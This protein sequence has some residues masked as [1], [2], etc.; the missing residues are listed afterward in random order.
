VRGDGAGAQVMGMEFGPDGALYTLDYGGGFFTVTSRSSLWKVSYIGGPSTP[1]AAPDARPG[2]GAREVRFSSRRSG[3]VSYEWDFGDGESSTAANPTH[4]YATAGD[5]AAKL[6]VTYADGGTDS[7]TVTAHALAQADTQAPV[8]TASLNPTQPGPGGTYSVPVTVTLTAE[9]AGQS[10]VEKTEYRVDGGE[11]KRY[12]A[13]FRVSEEGG[14]AVQFR[15]SDFADNVEAVQEV[16]FT[17]AVVE[18]CN[19]TRS[20]EFSGTQLDRNA[21]TVER[22]NAAALS[23][24]GGRLNLLVRAGDMIGA[25]NSAQNVLLRDAPDSGSWLVQTK[26]DI[27]ELTT[28]GE[29]AG[30][31]LWKSEDP[32]N[33]AKVVFINKG[34]GQRW[35]EYVLTTDDVN[36]RLPNTG[37]IANIPNDVYIRALSNGAGTIQAEYSLDGAEW[38]PIGPPITELGNDLKVGLKVSNNADSGHAARFDYFRIDCSDR[39]PP[40]T[41]ATVDPAQPNGGLGWYRT[42]PTVTL[43]ADDGAG[44]GVRSTEYAIDGGALQ[45]YSAPFKVEGAGDHTVR[46]RSTDDSPHE[47]QEAAKSLA[48]RVDASPPATTA[49]VDAAG[50]SARIALDARDGSGSGVARTEYR[51]DGGAWRTYARTDEPIFDGTAASL[52]QW[53]QAGS[54]HFDL[55]P[56]GAITPV[57]GLGMLW[58]P[59]SSYGDFA[60]KF[61]FRDG[62][63]D[64]GYSNGGAF[65]RFP[66]PRVPLAQRTDRCSKTGSAASDPAWVAIYCGHEIQLFDGPDGNGVEP[67][68]TGSIYN[69]SPNN[70]AQA[71]TTPRGEWNDYEVRVVGQ[72]Y[73]ITR[74]GTVIKEFDNVPGLNSSRPGDP[75]TT[76]RQFTV[77]YVGLQNHST[78]DL[79]QYRNMRVENLSGDTSAT[80]PFTVTG[81]G[82]HTV[83][84]RSV[85]WAGTTEVKRARTFRLGQRPQPSPPPAGNEP[86]TTAKFSLAKL[87]RTTLGGFARRGLAVEVACGD[88][89][90]GSAALTVTRRTMRRLH[91]RS[92]TLARRSVRCVQAGSK[93]VTLK[94]SRKVARA[95]RR[96]HGSV[97]ATV[98]VR[99][100]PIGGRASTH[101][102]RLTLRR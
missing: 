25:T 97:K 54:G 75:P 73:T 56:G 49:A 7:H 26:L 50:R 88:A 38:L 40:I 79:M 85:D 42:A 57:G 23:V 69:F 31:V 35:F 90:Q 71:H 84:F 43:T 29:Q 98:K 45:P 87:P 77:G 51:V 91:L 64:G 58:Y 48:L 72:H 82:L 61:Q 66:D 39:V 47:N 101:A 20:D 86:P 95:L 96:S 11:F 5:Y 36:R 93:T 33:F 27:S 63:T 17:I 3:G 62:R 70:L 102:R 44:D 92:A 12:T 89:M 9:D 67:Q 28:G 14:H 83:E 52:A 8:T 78:A 30:L 16:A 1:M 68:K 13:P 2:P 94:P 81:S 15:S 100:K 46:Y 4:T 18:T 74:N 22:E 34:N 6:T 99:L 65:V 41:T 80:G 59:V 10:G 24:S 60:F 19:P 76:D 32:N 53:S 37:A 21:W 55:L